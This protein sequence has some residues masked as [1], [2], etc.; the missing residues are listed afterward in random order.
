LS[1]L[2]DR[3]DTPT[4]VGVFRAVERPSYGAALQR[5]LAEASERSGPGDLAALLR[6]SPTWSVG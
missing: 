2:A 6:S 3:P 1:R 5:Q 4:P